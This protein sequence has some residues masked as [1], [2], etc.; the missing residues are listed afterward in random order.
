MQISR[1]Y[2]SRHD[3]PDRLFWY[4]VVLIVS[5]P[6]PWGSN[7]PWAC[8]L[9]LIGIFL[10]AM[11]WLW[12]FWQGQTDFTPAFRRSTPVLV[13]WALWLAYLLL[14]II[15][16][17]IAWLELLS[18]QAAQ[19]HRLADP[20]TGWAALSLDWQASYAGLLTSLAYVLLFCLILLTVRGQRQLRW[21]AYALLFSGVFQAVYGS[22]MTLSGLEIGFIY[23]KQ[24]Y[25][26]VATGTFVNRNHL[27]G[28][29][30]M[31]LAIG[32][33]LLLAQLRDT[34]L[35]HWR[36]VLRHLLEWIFSAKMLLRLSLVLMVIGLVLTHSRMGNVSFF[37]ALFVAS[38]LG[39]A[40]LRHAP[41]AAVTLLVT[42]IVI[43]VLIVGTWFGLEKVA[44]RLEQTSL[45]R[46]SRD[47]VAQASLDYWADYL[48]TGSG[49]G[50]YYSVFPSYQPETVGEFYDHA[51]NDYLEFATETGVV[52]IGLLGMAVLATL[53]RVLNTLYQRRTPLYRGMAFT[54]S[55]A[56]IALLIHSIAD[57]NLQI[58]ANAATFM[59]LLALGWTV[60]HLP[61]Q[62]EASSRL[63][64]EQRTSRRCFTLPL[65]VGIVGL[66][67][68]VAFSARL[69]LA[70]FY[71]Q[72]A[73]AY[74]RTPAG[75]QITEEQWQASHH[76]AIRGLAIN[77]Q[78]P[79]LYEHLGMLHTLRPQAEDRRLAT[80][81]FHQALVLRP[82][83][84]AAWAGLLFAKAKLREFD[85]QFEQALRQTANAPP[86]LTYARQA[87][88]E[89]GLE[90]WF[91]LSAKD[92][93]LVV[94][95]LEAGLASTSHQASIKAVERIL[96]ESRYR[97]ALCR[98]QPLPE[99]L[100]T[101]CMIPLPAP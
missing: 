20:D 88:M 21:L 30:V 18:P 40:F 62:Q 100:Q 82:V 23:E 47:E 14:Q 15:P 57:F 87:V 90:G 95:T 6:L 70:H 50:S 12:Q 98:Y 44:Q 13:L 27:A 31:C 28:Y 63:V 24:H 59:V 80:H 65:A 39:I 10:L 96:W 71:Y 64:T 17:P 72:E 68:L 77:S 75:Q 33:G 38:L 41:R 8:N 91:K 19:W 2:D 9:M 94:E 86:W 32:I 81:Y 5:L 48:L 78:T 52:G 89:A 46:E 54:V 93:A 67:I 11:T 3:R 101:F 26:G 85:A 16:L 83:S 43:D 74:L 53:I 60:S 79:T 99:R 37:S 56:I 61:G 22:L 69:G 76:A 25:Q 4:V 35:T 42:L 45:E 51:H 58:P 7:T 97:L 55:M 92:K 73:R 66:A 29:L 34:E 36:Q 1:F 84:P 49:L